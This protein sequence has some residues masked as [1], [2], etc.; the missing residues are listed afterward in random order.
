MAMNA[1]QAFKS[2]VVE[3]EQLRE[4]VMALRREARRSRSATRDL[5]TNL[6]DGQAA[7]GERSKS[8]K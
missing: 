2:G 7:Q 4:K 1:C 5:A 8:R 6:N 3:E